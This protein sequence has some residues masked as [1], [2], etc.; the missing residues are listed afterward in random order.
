MI[1]F[2][3]FSTCV[4]VCGPFKRVWYPFPVEFFVQLNFLQR[5]GKIFPENIPQLSRLKHWY[6]LE[7]FVGDPTTFLPLNI[8]LL[9]RNERWKNSIVFRLSVFTRDVCHSLL[10]FLSRSFVLLSIFSFFVFVTN[11][12]FSRLHLF[13][14]ISCYHILTFFLWLLFALYFLEILHIDVSKC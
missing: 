12:D 8:S 9:P 1:N 4:W 6:L 13:P 7:R 5:N 3:P 14:W 11:F 10:S 2:L